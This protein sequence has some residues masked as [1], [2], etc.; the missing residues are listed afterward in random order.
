MLEVA[1]E[2]M[3]VTFC[4]QPAW[5]EL[6]F[7]HGGRFEKPTKPSR[8]ALTRSSSPGMKRERSKNTDICD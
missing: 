1:G 3:G 8:D 6:G 5:A 7:V 2:E 4:G